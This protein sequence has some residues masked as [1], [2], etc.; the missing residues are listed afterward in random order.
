MSR[1]D[2]YGATDVTR[3]WRAVAITGAQFLRPDDERI[4]PPIE[5]LERRWQA[6]E[7]SWMRRWL[8]D[9]NDPCSPD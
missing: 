3:L 5:S 7:K 6:S 4:C 2:C 9:D 8:D 1:L